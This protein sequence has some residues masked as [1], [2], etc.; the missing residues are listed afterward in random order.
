M[1]P[2]LIQCLVE[3]SHEINKSRDSQ[4]NNLEEKELGEEENL[5]DGLLTIVIG[6]RVPL[7]QLALKKPH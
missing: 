4:N 7:H 1:I 3:E 6:L 5:K 2:Q